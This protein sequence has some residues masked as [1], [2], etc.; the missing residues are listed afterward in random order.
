MP[1][2]AELTRAPLPR[3]LA[4]S[5]SALFSGAEVV[6]ARVCQDL[7]RVG[8]ELDLVIA[9][10]NERLTVELSKLP[11]KA[12]LRHVPAQGPRLAGLQLRGPRLRRVARLVE[13]DRWDVLLC[14]L[15]SREFGGAPLLAGRALRG[16]AA[17][18]LLHVHRTPAENAFRF[19]RARTVASRGVLRR[20]HHLFVVAPGALTPLDRQ[21]DGSVSLLPLPRPLV[22]QPPHRIE[23]RRVLGLPP[24]A[25]VLALVGRLSMRQKGHDVLLDAVRL[26]DG[27]Q[28][29]LVVVFAGD[30]RDRRELESRVA[31]AGLSS[32]VRFL[33]ELADP[34]VAFAAADAVV[35]P[36]RFEGLPLVALEAAAH[37]RPGIVTDVDGLREVWPERWRVP[38]DDAAALAT[39][40]S[41]LLDELRASP[42]GV[43]AEVKRLQARVLALTAPSCAE[44]VLPR[45]RLEPAA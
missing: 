19:G 12:S 1:H 43:M 38:P 22:G 31:R 5:D 40:L 28:R 21:L 13:D 20:L 37:G 41:G 6:F 15:P 33:G 9:D 36:S 42:Q 2:P 23:A 16:R 14:N 7:D 24:G 35:I 26:L 34:G 32:T 27:S 39:A 10:E 29:G 25:D 17:V 18:G 3:V 44:T 11:R 45:L 8:V 4:Y 30:G